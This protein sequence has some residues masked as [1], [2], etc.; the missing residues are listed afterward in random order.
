MSALDT[1]VAGKHYR[2][3]RIQPIEFIAANGLNFIEGSVIKYICR[4]R[5]KNG[6]QDIQKIIH[7][8]QLLIELEYGKGQGPDAANSERSEQAAGNSKPAPVQHDEVA[9]YKT[10][11]E[12]YRWLRQQVPP[13]D[14]MSGAPNWNVS[15]Q[16]NGMGT[17]LRNEQL[18]YAIDRARSA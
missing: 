15:Y 2:T 1:Q 8:C 11:A 14:F 6:V 16:A 3:M 7:Y 10:D 13:E 4:H 9:F 17:V 5:N 18:D 12:R